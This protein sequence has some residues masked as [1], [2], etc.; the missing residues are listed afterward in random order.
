MSRTNRFIASE[1]KS[2]QGLKVKVNKDRKKVKNLFNM[3]N[4][5]IFEVETIIESLN[6]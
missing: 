1:K 2:K 5:S 4:F 3:K 6:N